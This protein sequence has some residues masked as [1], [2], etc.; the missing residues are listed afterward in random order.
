MSL[1]NDGRD[2]VRFKTFSRRSLILSGGTL[3]LFSGLLARMYQLQVL[4][5]DR[6]A[7][8]A[9][10]NRINM[11][12]LAPLRGRILD[13]FGVP[14]ATNRQ[15]YR[16]ILIP[17][18]TDSVERALD[19]VS[20]YI[21]LGAPQREK[22]L[23]EVRRNPRFVPITVAENL[24][25]EEFA[26]INFHAPELPGF[27]LDAGE[28][29][30]YP[31]ADKLSHILGYV[32]AVSE[33]DLADPDPVLRIPGFRIGKLG[34]ERQ[35]DPALRGKAGVRQVE[36]NASG[37]KIREL[38]RRVGEPGDDVVLTLDMEIQKFAQA[39][40]AEE[41]AACVVMDVHSGD[42][43]ALVSN[44][45]FDPNE[46]NRG[47][48]HA[49]Y[50]AL[51]SDP[52]LP[53]INKAIAG[54][55]PPGSTF[56]PLVALAAL[57]NNVISPETA[58]HCSGATWLGNHAFHCWKKGGHGAMNLIGG[59]K[60]SCD[61]YFYE[62]ARRLG[63]DRIEEMCHRFGLGETFKFEVPGEKTG[64]VP[65]RGWKQATTGQ[66]WQQ[67]ETLITGIGQGYV[68]TTPLQLCV[69]TARLANGGRK[70]M[71]HIFRSVGAESHVRPEAD[72]MGLS[73]RALQ[74]VMNGMNAVTNEGG[75]AAR[76]RID[77]EGFEMA[78]K[79]GTSQV[80]RITREERARG[81]IKN[82]DL[83]WERRDHALFI[84]YAPVAAP[85][86]AIS[87]IVE[88][89]GSGSKAAAPPARDIMLLTLQRDPSR[90]EAIPPIARARRGTEEG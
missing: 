43:L 69:M 52:K 32:A 31:Y 57:E 58:I 6:Y 70:V 66:S 9:E 18:Q 67:G 86:Y 85:R 47:I 56:K 74:L 54:Q 27:I 14:L 36:V 15:N 49:S 17:E 30:D 38:S 45:G 61:I 10:D 77:I 64:L 75:T 33:K 21:I 82:E 55:Y 90:M 26:A 89:G 37:R 80:R 87:L 13:R 44:P 62:L 42:V 4:E 25:W 48:S 63:I 59:L 68:L 40:L 78:G 35:V 79:T 65:S 39:R 23:K 76:S 24:S 22:I 51:L 5:Q 19:R 2:H 81:V 29:R 34:I 7:T 73:D 72:L 16:V 20:Q 83:P 84:A 53:L 50:Q 28:T 1:L 12:L 3:A 8:L 71:P 11:E 41:A 88:H 46:F 60:H